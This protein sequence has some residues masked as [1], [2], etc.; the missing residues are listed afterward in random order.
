MFN[1]RVTKLSVA[2]L[3]LA[4]VAALAPHAAKAVTA[5]LVQVAN[6]VAAPAVTQ[7]VSEMA[8]QR[9]LLRLP[10]GASLSPGDPLTAMYQVIPNT[11]Q[12]PTFFTVPAGQNLIITSMTVNTYNTGGAD[13]VLLGGAGVNPF[14]SVYVAQKGS[15][16]IPFRNGLVFPAGSAVYIV[17]SANVAGTGS[18]DVVVGGYLTAN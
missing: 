17:N 3:V 6:T 9:V 7:S 12:S 15:Q 18:A 4:A 5:A 14:Y 16:T 10:F 13:I 8:S 11:G 1:T 2:A